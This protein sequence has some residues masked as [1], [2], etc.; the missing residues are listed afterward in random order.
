[1][2]ATIVLG[3]LLL[4]LQGLLVGHMTAGWWRHRVLPKHSGGLVFALGLATIVFLC[5]AL[6][7]IH[8]SHAP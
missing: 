6:A 5:A 8:L 1:L 3:T 7:S 2:D 4:L